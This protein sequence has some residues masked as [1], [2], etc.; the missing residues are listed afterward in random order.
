[1]EQLFL[2]STLENLLLSCCLKIVLVFS[3]LVREHLEGFQ[4]ELNFSFWNEVKLSFPIFKLAGVTGHLGYGRGQFYSGYLWVVV[5][6][7]TSNI[8]HP[9]SERQS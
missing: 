1:M 2:L 5:P 6:G 9:E 3:P 8:L 4:Q 7:S